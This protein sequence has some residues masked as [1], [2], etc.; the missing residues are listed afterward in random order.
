MT[1]LQF[2]PE[3]YPQQ[4]RLIAQRVEEHE[5]R[6]RERKNAQQKAKRVLKVS[7]SPTRRKNRRLTS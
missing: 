2:D 6:M 4:A 3:Q 5:R 7:T 1:I